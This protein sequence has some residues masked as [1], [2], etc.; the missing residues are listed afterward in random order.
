[1]EEIILYSTHCAKCKILEFKLKQQ[2]IEFKEVT[3]IEIMTRKGFMSVPMLETNGI[4]M[5]FAQANKWINER[6]TK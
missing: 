5:N 1:M 2:G 4:I 6:V 3:D